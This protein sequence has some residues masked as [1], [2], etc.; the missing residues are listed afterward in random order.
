[1]AVTLQELQDRINLDGAVIDYINGNGFNTINE[2]PAQKSY[3]TLINRYTTVIK[4][5]TDLAS[6]D[7]PKNERDELLEFIK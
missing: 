7:I 1:M 4:Q 5:L 2:H 3:N 6:K